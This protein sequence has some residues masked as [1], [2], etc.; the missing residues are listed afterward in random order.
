MYVVAKGGRSFSQRQRVMVA[1]LVVG[2]CRYRRIEDHR[3]RRQ[4]VASREN[5]VRHADIVSRIYVA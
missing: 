5:L 3:G 1:G 4:Y 2:A